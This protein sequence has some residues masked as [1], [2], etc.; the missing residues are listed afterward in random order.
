MRRYDQI[1]NVDGTFPNVTA[2]ESTEPADPSGTPFYARLINDQWGARQSLLRAGILTPDGSDESAGNSQTLEAIRRIANYDQTWLNNWYQRTP[3][4]GYLG[5]F[6]AARYAGT[7]FVIAGTLG[8]IQTSPTGK[9][10]TARTPAGGYTGSFRGITY[11]AGLYVLVGQ[12]GEIQTS[13]DGIAWTKRTA[14]GGYTGFFLS[15]TYHYTP[16]L[17]VAVGENGE[18]QTSPDGIT[19]TK[20]TAAG[21]YTGDFKGVV[22]GNGLFVA[23]GEDKEIESSPDGVTW[24]ARTPDM[25]PDTSFECILFRS[26]LNQ[27]V[28]GGN[29]G[30]IQISYNGIDWRA[31]TSPIG[32]G[33]NGG[34][35]HNGSFVFVSG[36]LQIVKSLDGNNWTVRA[37]DIGGSGINLYAAAYDNDRAVVVGTQGTIYRS[38]KHG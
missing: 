28:T 18:I 2:R 26:G 16:A 20:R 35:A 13:P 11:G 12:N 15:V 9:I 31:I 38:L 19:W 4:A 22:Y 24:T 1:P 37:V 5:T 27:F 14:A 6:R 7:L 33:L 21:G 23:V 30:G 34:I 36:S 8:A 25:I 32:Y 17:F 10:W 29:A 3:A